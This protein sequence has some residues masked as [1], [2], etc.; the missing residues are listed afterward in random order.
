[1]K[2]N[3]TFLTTEVFL[4]LGVKTKALKNLHF[5]HF[6]GLRGWNLS[7][8]KNKLTVGPVN[9]LTNDEGCASNVL[10]LLFLLKPST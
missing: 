5:S 8:S 6:S 9:V 7:K 3:L 2:K 4:C 1:M 10:C